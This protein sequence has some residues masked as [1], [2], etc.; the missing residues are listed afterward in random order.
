[1]YRLENRGSMKESGGRKQGGASPCA[2][3]KLLRRRCARDCV[4]APYFPADD[5]QKFATVH[6]V[7]GASNVNKL[8][9]VSPSHPHSSFLPS[10]LLVSQKKSHLDFDN[11]YLK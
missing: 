6:R 5:P 4:F 9:Q 11:C 2:A 3:C 8:L 7:F 1:M 10:Y